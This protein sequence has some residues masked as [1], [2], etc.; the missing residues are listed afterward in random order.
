MRRPQHDSSEATRLEGRARR[1]E[2]KLPTYQQLLDEALDGTFPASDP[3]APGAAMHTARRIS[4]AKDDTD[5]T[6]LP[7]GRAASPTPRR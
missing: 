2:D 7:G 3:I 6:L 1:T 4:T 5:W